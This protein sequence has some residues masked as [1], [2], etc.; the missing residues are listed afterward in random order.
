MDRF[1]ELDPDCTNSLVLDTYRLESRLGSIY[2]NVVEVVPELESAVFDLQINHTEEALKRVCQIVFDVFPMQDNEGS[3]YPLITTQEQIERLSNGETDGVCDC[4]FLTIFTTYIVSKLCSLE[5][6]VSIRSYS[7][8]PVLY[9]KLNE[10]PYK[11]SYLHGKP[12]ID[13][14]TQGDPFEIGVGDNTSYFNDYEFTNSRSILYSKVR[15]AIFVLDCMNLMRR[16]VVNFVLD[17]YKY[18]Q[19]FESAASI[20]AISGIFHEPIVDYWRMELDRIMDLHEMRIRYFKTD[21][22]RFRFREEIISSLRF[23]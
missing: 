11:I 2:N 5:T 6:N 8:H 7:G 9:V 12:Y 16:A 13:Q 17:D 23:I 1:P 4:K 15:D 14:Y 18:L 22:D 21:S 3:E 10:E 19:I 20:L